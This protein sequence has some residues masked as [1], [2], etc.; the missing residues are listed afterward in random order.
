MPG[1]GVAG[2]KRGAAVLIPASEN[3]LLTLRR[4]RPIETLLRAMSFPQALPSAPRRAARVTPREN[5]GDATKDVP[6][7]RTI[8]REARVGPPNQSSGSS[9]TRPANAGYGLPPISP[10]HTTLLNLAGGTRSAS[11][12]SKP[13]VTL[14]Q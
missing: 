5:A 11:E 6:N 13:A 9:A 3:V 7:R 10:S 1:C 8:P 2:N 4:A 12:K 14:A